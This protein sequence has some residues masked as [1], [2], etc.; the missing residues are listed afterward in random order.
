MALGHSNLWMPIVASIVLK[1][2]P[3][4]YAEYL[5]GTTPQVRPAGWA[6]HGSHILI[7]DLNRHASNGSKGGLYPS[8]GRDDSACLGPFGV[9]RASLVKQPITIDTT[10]GST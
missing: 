6:D 3:H 5:H 7:P 9:C 4:I 10:G 8:T 2:A 1:V